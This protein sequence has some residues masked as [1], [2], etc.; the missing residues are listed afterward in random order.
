MK[1]PSHVELNLRSALFS[2]VFATSMPV[3]ALLT[4][5]CAPFPFRVR[6]AVATRWARL[7][8]WWLKRSCKL[9]YRVI[10][11]E[12][13]PRES[14]IIFSKHQSAW[15]TLAL[16][17]IFPPQVWVMKRELLWVPFFGWALAMLGAIAIDR[18]AG[19]KAISQLVTQG[20]ER[21][22]DGRWVVV[23][24]EGTRIAPGKKG[25]YR[26]GGAVLAEQTGHPIV[27]VAHNAGEFWTRRGF[28]KRPGEIQVMIGPVIA[29]QGRAAADILKDAETWIEDAMER[30]KQT[31]K[32]ID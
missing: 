24:P 9:R 21:L 10:G 11:A 13:I 28:I 3:F 12:N 15:E 30:I 26:I 19:R 25:R 16:Q 27:P 14:S 18:K 5:L 22:N 2:L 29:T 7:N 32:H 4:M 23:F 6:Y 17:E 8:L 31:Q 1:P 20:R